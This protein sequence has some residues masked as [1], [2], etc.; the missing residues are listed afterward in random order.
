M[1]I[2]FFL[3]FFLSLANPPKPPKLRLLQI[4][5]KPQ[6]NLTKKTNKQQ[7]SQSSEKNI[8]IFIDLVLTEIDKK[9]FTLIENA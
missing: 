5:S 7:K 8:D 1:K 9:E 6:K 3:P 2:N 4:S